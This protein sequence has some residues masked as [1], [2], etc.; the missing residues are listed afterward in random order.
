MEITTHLGVYIFLVQTIMACN[1]LR[2]CTWNIKRSHSSKRKKIL[3]CLKKEKVDIALLQETHLNDEEHLELQ[4]GGFD[5]VFFSF[6]TT[7]SRGVAILIRKNLPIKVL[8]CVKDNNGRFVLNT[9]SLNGEEFC[10]LNVYC[11]PGHPLEFLTET[12]AKLCDLAVE[13]TIVE[14]DFNCL[15]Y[16]LMDRFPLGI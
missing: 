7:R 6:F 12:F 1:R 2:L 11:S 3:S 15:K 4:R 10:V 14:G 5:Q 9:T 13:N 8:K 16:P